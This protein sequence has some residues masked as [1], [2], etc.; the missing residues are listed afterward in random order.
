MKVNKTKYILCILFFLGFLNNAITQDRYYKEGVRYFEHELYHRALKEFRLDQN[1]DNNKD[2]VLKRLISNYEVNNI[3]AAKKDVP[4]LLAFDQIPDEVYLYIAKIFHSELNFEKAIEYYKEYLRKTSKN[5]KYRTMVIG[6]IKRCAKGDQLQYYEHKA[7]VENMG[8]EINTIF[9]ETDPIQSPNNLNKYYFS[10]NRIE[11]IGGMR[12]KNGLKDD[13][14]GEFYLDMYSG[15]LENGKWTEIKPLNA[16]LNTSKHERVLDFNSDGSILFFLKGENQTM[17]AIHVDTFG[18]QKSEIYPPKFSSPMNGEKGDIYFQFFNDS[19]VIFSSK[20]TGGYGGY[21]IYIMYKINSTWSRPKNLGPKINSPY[22]EITPFLS[23]DGL[24]LFFSSNSLESIGG[25][26]VFQSIY[27]VEGNDWSEPEN[28]KLGINS[29]LDDTHYKISSN[30]MLAYFRSNRKSGFGKGDLYTAY[31]KEQEIGQLSYNPVLPFLMT[32][33]FV[34]DRMNEGSTAAS[35]NI[36]GQNDGNQS[37][38]RDL[39]AN[40]KSKEFV[41]EPLFYGVDDNLLTLQNLKILNNI[42]D[43]MSIYPSTSVEIDCHSMPE[44]QK[45]FELYFTIKRAEKIAEY[46]ISNGVEKKRILLRGHGSNY[47]LVTVD[48]SGSTNNLAEKLNR[49]IEIKIIKKETL[50]LI[51][52]YNAPVV[53]DYLKDNS[54]ELLKTVILGLS[55]RIKIAE[56]RQMYQND[57]LSQYQD[58]LIQ[59]NFGSDNYVYTIGLYKSYFD[60]QDVLKLLENDN[61]K[62]TLII[63]YMNGEQMNP[64]S[65]MDLASKYPDLVNYLQYKGH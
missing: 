45:A 3:E 9:D 8:P 7:F 46:L 57:I 55:Y 63:P 65:L 56:V 11:S 64:D 1:G 40:V 52:G 47:P 13:I 24:K 62:G 44:S 27:S 49:R 4:L 14:Y 50:P 53:A 6:E 54:G 51:I 42:V 29:A 19:T 33:E 28:L 15:E 25:F 12:D 39:S 60:A 30:G 48:N 37:S 58:V 31:L 43:I 35:D 41:I 10:S 26:D 59:K 2:L 34:R 21:D 22:D 16:L 23:H 32:D 20:R 61:I 5:D 36:T 18:T 17:G 38:G